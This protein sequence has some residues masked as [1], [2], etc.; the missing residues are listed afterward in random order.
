M[1]IETRAR[2]AHR[3]DPNLPQLAYL[4]RRAAD[5]RDRFSATS[6]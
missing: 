4:R 6:R 5:G 3:T 2:A 1:T